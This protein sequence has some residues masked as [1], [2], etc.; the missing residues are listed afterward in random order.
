MEYGRYVISYSRNNPEVIFISA[1]LFLLICTAGNLAVDR[2]SNADLLIVYAFY[3]L[4]IGIGFQL[5]KVRSFA[6]NKNDG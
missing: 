4:I 1:F 3:M 2:Q 6:K 5:I